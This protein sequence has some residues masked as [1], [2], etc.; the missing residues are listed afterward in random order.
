MIARTLSAAACAVSSL[1]G[2][3]AAVTFVD[4]G[5]ASRSLM[6]CVNSRLCGMRTLRT[7]VCVDVAVSSPTACHICQVAAASMQNAVEAVT[8]SRSTIHRAADRRAGGG[9]VHMMEVGRACART[10][11][12]G[13][14][15]LLEQELDSEKLEQMHH[16]V[17]VGKRPA[18][19]GVG[20]PF[21]G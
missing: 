21:R 1:P 20:G 15:H 7:G 10:V 17:I 4:G 13:A 14:D 5:H 19:G 9:D 16:H 3:H 6:R 12:G 11:R 2:A 18:S 8:S